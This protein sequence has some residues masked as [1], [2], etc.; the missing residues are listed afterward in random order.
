MG[1]TINPRKAFPIGNVPYPILQ[2][3]VPVG[4]APSGT[5]A[6]NGA[7]TL[8]TALNTT[9]SSGIWLYFA[10]GAVYAGSSA[11]FFW[12]VMSSTTVGTVYDN[13]YVPG[14]TS[15]DIPASPTAISAAGPGAFTG[16]TTEIT[17]LSVTVPGGALGNHGQLHYSCFVGGPNNA[18]NKADVIRFDGTQAGG[19]GT[20]INN[21]GRIERVE[22]RNMGQPDKQHSTNW[23][24]AG[25]GGTSG[26]F[27][28]VD[29]ASDAAFT[30]TL[31]LSVATDYLILQGAHILLLPS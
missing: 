30:Q 27:L 24:T 2:C 18:N 31:Q 19:I 26:I 9:Y 28:S 4:I 20:F 23:V 12:T 8:G 3:G 25:S 5:M 1:A 17:A 10:S 6:A 22:I 15:F 11:G 16:V 21:L 29:T 7:V 13:T 14:S